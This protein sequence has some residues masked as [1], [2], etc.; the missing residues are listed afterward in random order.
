MGN[1]LAPGLHEHLIART[2]FIDDL[3]E[4]RRSISTTTGA[5]Q[6]VILGAG[7]DL[8]AHRVLAVQFI[9]PSSLI[10]FPIFEVRE[11]AEVQA[12]KR[13][14]LPK[15]DRKQLRSPLYETKKRNNSENVTYVAVDFTHQCS[16]SSTSA[17]QLR[18]APISPLQVLI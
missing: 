18:H 15:I 13:S 8:R 6:Y 2:R 12:R 7:Y 11:Q 3:I 1:K 14:K 4:K 16:K 5:E 17:E 9:F 10:L